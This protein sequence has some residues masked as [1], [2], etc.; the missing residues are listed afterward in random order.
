MSTTSGVPEGW[1]YPNP[2]MV[3]GHA[4]TG[5]MVWIGT[6][7]A[8]PEDFLDLKFAL[9]ETTGIDLLSVCGKYDIRWT[10]QYN[11]LTDNPIPSGGKGSEC[12]ELQHVGEI[13]NGVKFAK[14]P[15]F[16]YNP[17]DLEAGIQNEI[18]P[19]C[20]AYHQIVSAGGY[21]DNFWGPEPASVAADMLG[22][23]EYT[24]DEQA[25]LYRIKEP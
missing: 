15:I 22:N 12:Y 6:A 3:N 1:S 10:T 2:V 11:V 25:C 5:G 23:G 20:G 16:A 9:G 18:P 13:G 14:E 19:N 17:D 4:H 24:W 7:P 8:H 21:I